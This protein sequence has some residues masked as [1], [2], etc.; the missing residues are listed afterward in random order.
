VSKLPHIF[1]ACC[2]A[3]SSSGVATNTS[4]FV[5]AV[6]FACSQ[7]CKGHMCILCM[8]AILFTFSSVLLV[9]SYFSFILQFSQR[10]L[11]RIW[12]VFLQ[13]RCSSVIQPT[14][15]KHWIEL[16]NADLY[17]ERL[18]ALVSSFFVHLPSPNRITFAP[19]ML[20]VW[21][22]ERLMWVQYCK[23]TEV[24]FFH[25]KLISR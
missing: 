10:E 18:S 21:C 13:A 2:L 23:W 24:R 6:M 12:R 4:G 3:W 9:I 16:K 14:V 5:D 7:P 15:S 8:R 19:C 25:S 1:C 11:L 20:A 22:R 17:H